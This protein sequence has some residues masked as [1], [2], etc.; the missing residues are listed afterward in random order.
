MNR[1]TFLRHSSLVT[2]AA[3]LGAPQLL[4]QAAEASATPVIGDGAFK[5]ECH[6]Y[7]GQLPDG[8]HYGDATHGVAIDSQGFIYIS[9]Q[10]GPGSV[11]V[12]DP[13]GKFVRS[14]APQHQGYGHGI[15]IRLEGNDDFIYLSPNNF[16]LPPEKWNKA[17]KLTVKGDV[18]WEGGP[19]PQSHRYDKGESFNPT[20]ISFCPDGGWH[21]GDGYGSNFLHRYDAQG[22]YLCTFGGGGKEKGQLATPHGHWFDGR[23]GIP[24]VAVCDRGNHR[25]QY[26]SLDGQFLSGIPD[27]DGPASL[28]TRGDVMVCTEVFIGRLAFLDP[29]GRVLARL[30]DDPAWIKTIKETSGFRGLAHKDKWLPGKFVHPHDATFDQQG[31]LFVT[32]WVTGGRLTKL[33]HVA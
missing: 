24:K 33:R 23:N 31:N 15:D 10:G 16:G 8:H 2:T 3:T 19:P 4:L 1:R 7:W 21:V 13:E 14:M 6:H 17:Q 29:E 5:F 26:F 20:N 27:I 18:V 11:F 32:E 28:D 22:N 25:I 30:N 12:F 9:H